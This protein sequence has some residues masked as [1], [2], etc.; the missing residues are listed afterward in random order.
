MVVESMWDSPGRVYVDCWE[1]NLG[2][3]GIRCAYRG[4]FIGVWDGG[5][6]DMGAELCSEEL[7]EPQMWGVVMFREAQKS[8]RQRSMLK[9]RGKWAV[10]RCHQSPKDQGLS[11]TPEVILQ[12]WKIL[13]PQK[14]GTTWGSIP[15]HLTTEP[16]ASGHRLSR[17]AQK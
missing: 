4:S 15:N 2:M 7:Q 3:T 9:L 11:I 14:L 10:G 6:G 1:Q 5:I 17:A 8:L 16:Q 12:A 13:E